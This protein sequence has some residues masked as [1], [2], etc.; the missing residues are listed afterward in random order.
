MDSE[1]ALLIVSE[2]SKKIPAT[3]CIIGVGTVIDLSQLDDIART[4][5]KFAVSPIH[6]EG[7]VHACH[8]RGILALPAA[9]TPNELWNT[10]LQGAL[11][12]KLF[13]AQLWTPETLKVQP[14]ECNSTVHYM[15]RNEQ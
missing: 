6:P 12:V 8:S 5:A 15:P 4:G 10:K 1:N 7:M 2:L 3:K 11:M 14:N 13:P 9:S